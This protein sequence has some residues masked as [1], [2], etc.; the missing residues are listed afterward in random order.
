MRDQVRRHEQLVD[1][2]TREA[3]DGVDSAVRS[4]AWA[5]ILQLRQRL[6]RARAILD[7]L[8]RTPPY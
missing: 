2:Y 1:A 5:N 4:Y 7:R 3:V 6:T 8:E